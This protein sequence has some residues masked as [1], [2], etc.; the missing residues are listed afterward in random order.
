[1]RNHRRLAL[2]AAVLAAALFTA[3]CSSGGGSGSSG[4]SSGGASGGGPTLAS[5]FVFGAPPDCPTNKFCAEGLKTTYGIVFKEVKPL[6]FGGPETVAAL[7]SGAIQVGELFS[8]SVYDPD[9]V[10]LTD[11]KHL[12]AADNIAPVVRTDVATDDV[13]NLLNGVSA[14]LDTSGMLALNKQVDIDHKDVADVATSFLQTAGLLGSATTTGKGTTL[15]VGVSG[16]FSESKLVAEM[17]AQVLENA[18]Y[19]VKRQLNLESRKV[20]DPALF[21]GKIDIKPEYLA[22]EAVA[23]DP[24]AAV[25]GDTQNNFTVLSGLLQSKNVTV[26]TPSAAIDTNVFVVTKSTADKYGLA[27]VSDLAK[28]AS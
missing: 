9:F 22:S 12:E 17:Y 8:T 28:P 2:G 25:S 26:L 23:Q 16:A 11:D 15:T 13:T 27:N 4:G 5:T 18:G 14:K 21:S 7:K 6:D 10:V 1:M 19:T 24:N 20:S 3:A